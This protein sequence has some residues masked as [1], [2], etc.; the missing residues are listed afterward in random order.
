[1]LFHHIVPWYE[2]LVIFA[3]FPDKLHTIVYGSY[4][5][6]G[7]DRNSFGGIS[8]GGTILVCTAERSICGM[9]DV[10]TLAVLIQLVASHQKNIFDG[11]PECVFASILDG[12][13]LSL[14]VYSFQS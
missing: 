14:L 4:E 12:K 1:M 5:W 2:F 13:V 10:L 3:G 6:R 9:L 8:D 7:I 11:L